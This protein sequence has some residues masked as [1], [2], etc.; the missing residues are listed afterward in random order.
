MLRVTSGMRDGKDQ[1]G[2]AFGSKMY[3]AKTGG[4]VPSPTVPSTITC[5]G[6]TANKALVDAGAGHQQQLGLFRPDS[7]QNPL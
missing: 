7:Q 4:S 3:A 2:I 5:T 1:H 6:I